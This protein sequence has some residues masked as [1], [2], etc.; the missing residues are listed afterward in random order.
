[1]LGRKLQVAELDR[2]DPED[3][4]IVQLDLSHLAAVDERAVCAAIV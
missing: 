2:S 3:I 1:V 4:A